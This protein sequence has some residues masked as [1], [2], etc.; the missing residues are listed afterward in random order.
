[1]HLTPIITKK[2]IIKDKHTFIVSKQ[3]RT[4]FFRSTN[5]LSRLKTKEKEDSMDGR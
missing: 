1:M 5:R 2:N 3:I 4:K